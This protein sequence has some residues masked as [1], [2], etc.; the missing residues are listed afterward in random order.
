M[1]VKKRKFKKGMIVDVLN[2]E[3]GE[4]ESFGIIKN[5]K[6]QSHRGV[7]INSKGETL[8]DIHG[9][10][11]GFTRRES[12]LRKLPKSVVESIKGATNGK[13]KKRKVGKKINDLPERIRNVVLNINTSE[14]WQKYLN[15]RK[16]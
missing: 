3:T 13:Y 14:F 4:H 16:N 8:R 6:N 5:I 1:N 2:P 12:N 11:K 7:K 10:P 9:H 15:N